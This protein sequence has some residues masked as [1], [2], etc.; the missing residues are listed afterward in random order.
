[1]LG[2]KEVLANTIVV[3]ILQ[4]EN[5]PNQYAVNLKFSQCDISITSQF[6]NV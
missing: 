2:I 5:V 6:K 4:Y 1:M 3:I